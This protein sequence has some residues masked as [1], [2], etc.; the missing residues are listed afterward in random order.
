MDIEINLN[1][2]SLT[3]TDIVF[4]ANGDFA[5]VDGSLGILQNILQTLKVYLGEWYLNTNIGLDYYGQILVK[6]PKQSAIDAIFINA[7]LGVAGV[8]QLNSYS[9]S[10]N[11]I[12]RQL[13]VS[14]SAQTT[15]GIVDYEGLI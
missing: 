2:A 4:Q 5:T 9:F 12:T 11:F 6:N 8:Q 3:F 15:S 13:T 1:P 14:F 10:P 7:I